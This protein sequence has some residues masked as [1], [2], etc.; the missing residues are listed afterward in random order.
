MKSGY[1]SDSVSKTKTI[2]ATAVA[3]LLYCCTPKLSP[4]AQADAERGKTAW[5][6]CS[7]EKLTAAHNLYINKCGACHNLKLPQSKSDYVW[8]KIVPDMA[9]RAKMSAA[10][11]ELILHYVLTMREAVAVKK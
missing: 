10:E 9:E 3:L 7:L 1:Y 11:E 2:V 4:P 8:R 5:N 6:D